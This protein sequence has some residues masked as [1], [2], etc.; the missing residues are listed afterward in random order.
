M[1][2]RY[3]HGDPMPKDPWLIRVAVKYPKRAALIFV[4][5]AVVTATAIATTIVGG[6]KTAE[7]LKT[8][9][10][11]AQFSACIRDES[12]KSREQML[13]AGWEWTIADEQSKVEAAPDCCKSLGRVPLYTGESVVCLKPM[14]VDLSYSKE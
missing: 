2:E 5:V 3:E 13:K 8:R 1:V 10:L 4:V 6:M 12:F 14:Y 11:K 9:Q 7:D